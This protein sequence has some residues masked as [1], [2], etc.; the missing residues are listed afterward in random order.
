LFQIIEAENDSLASSMAVAMV[1]N[2]QAEI[3]MKG[4]VGTDLFLK[5]VMDKEKGLMLPGLFKLCRAIQIPAYHNCC[6]LTDPA[7]IPY[8][9]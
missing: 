4:L 8:R 6:L 9:T 5:A 1:K 2:G 7:V 3:V